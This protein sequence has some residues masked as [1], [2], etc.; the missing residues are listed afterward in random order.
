[1]RVPGTAVRTRTGAEMPVLGFGTWRMGESTRRRKDEVAAVRLALDLGIRLVDTAEMYGSGETERIVAEAIEGRR[2]EIFLVSKVL[3]SNASREGTILAARES[4]RRLR[5]DRLDLYL[6]HWPGRHPLDETLEAFRVLREAGDVLHYGLSN[7]DRE[8]MAGAEDLPGGD[9]VAADQVLYNLERRG[10]ERDLIPWC[11]ERNVAVMA[12]APLEQGRLAV[13]DALKRVAERHGASPERVALA[14]M[15]A[16]PGVVALVKATSPEHVRDDAAAADLALA[17]EDMAEL[18]R[19]YPRP[20][21]EV[22][23]GTL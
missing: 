19:D 17:P 14:W 23:L 15:T 6:L 21:G 5:T 4:L 3:P 8:D 9:E 16:Q 2:D 7:F 18:D 11:R 10:I 20:K 13:R 1:M 12:Y 22:P